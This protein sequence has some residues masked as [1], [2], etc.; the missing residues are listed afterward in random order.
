MFAQKVIIEDIRNVGYIARSAIA[1]K[2]QYL[3]IAIVVGACRY[4][5]FVHEIGGFVHRHAEM[6]GIFPEQIGAF[7]CRERCAHHRF[8]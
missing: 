8:E 1:E 2:Y 4:R 5:L 7:R 3:R 6:C